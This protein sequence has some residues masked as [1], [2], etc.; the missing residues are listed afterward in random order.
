MR[1][2]KIRGGVDVGQGIVVLLDCF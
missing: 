1:L 2:T